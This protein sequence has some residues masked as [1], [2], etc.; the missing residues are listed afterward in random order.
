MRYIV[1]LN[2]KEYAVEVANGQAQIV[3]AAKPA[4]APAPKA[5][6]APAPKAAP[7]PAPSPAP[8][9]AAPAAAGKTVIEAP[10][11]GNVFKVLVKAG[12]KVTS[13]QAVIVLEA[14]K[15][16]NE[17]FSPCDG[18]VASVNVT[19]GGT[20]NTGDVMLTIN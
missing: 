5:A 6:P 4:A 19:E 7:A 11:P 12:D 16:E 1:T 17:V 20:V 3:D 18:V 8:A 15:M 9:P 13:G 10:L 2:G 14:M